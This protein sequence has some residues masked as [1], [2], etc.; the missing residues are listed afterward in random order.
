MERQKYTP[1]KGAYYENQGGGYYRCMEVQGDYTALM[2]NTKSGW[3]LVAHGVGIYPDGKIDWDYSSG[4]GFIDKA[5]FVK[6]VCLIERKIAAGIFYQIMSRCLSGSG[7]YH[8]FPGKLFTLEEAKSAA[9]A[10][11]MNVIATGDTWQCL[12]SGSMED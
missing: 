7:F 2:V 5:A 3:Q 6:D 8:I 11:A 1:A 4:L 12:R 10:Y 9:K